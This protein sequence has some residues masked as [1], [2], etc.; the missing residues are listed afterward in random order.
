M[1][2]LLKCI[3]LWLLIMWHKESLLVLCNDNG[4]QR[5]SLPIANYHDPKPIS[6]DVFD[7]FS[8]GNGIEKLRKEIDKLMSRGCSI[9]NGTV[10]TKQNRSSEYLRSMEGGDGVILRPNISCPDEVLI[11]NKKLLDL[12]KSYR[13]NFPAIGHGNRP[14]STKARKGVIYEPYEPQ[15]NSLP[16]GKP[17][18][19]RE[20]TESMEYG[21]MTIYP[22]DKSHLDATST[23]STEL[24]DLLK[25][26][27][28]SFPDIDHGNRPSRTKAQK[29]VVY[30]P[31]I[32]PQE[33]V[34]SNVEGTSPSME[35]I[36][37]NIEKNNNFPNN[38]CV[39]CLNNILKLD[40]INGSED[41][42]S[43]CCDSM[44][45][46][47]NTSDLVSSE[48]DT[49][50]A[51]N[52]SAADL[53]AKDSSLQN[54]SS[55]VKQGGHNSTSLDNTATSRTRRSRRKKPLFT[56]HAAIDS[57]EKLN[58]L[59]RSPSHGKDSNKTGY[60]IAVVVVVI[61]AVLVVVM[62]AVFFY[63]KRSEFWKW[64]HQRYYRYNRQKDILL[65]DTYI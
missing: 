13:D 53:R 10:V 8:P 63:K 39:C 33:G 28:E 2:M 6:T 3:G 26:Y 46:S 18:T 34:D 29:G 65:D 35:S 49:A 56:R 5:F 16:S 30:E 41:D 54:T 55:S 24:S 48:S 21:G 57:P 31:Q 1:G 9:F 27:H 62:F 14:S 45:N 60:V 32:V 4:P 64:T 59:S 23:P 42:C 47:K 52:V 12:L 37:E 61:L 7:S 36:D 11:L 44:Q 19:P 51:V 50:E 15:S 20:Y 38:T 40:I 43:K 25:S 22:D 17:N 58:L